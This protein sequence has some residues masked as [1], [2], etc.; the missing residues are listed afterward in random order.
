M[1]FADCTSNFTSNCGF[2]ETTI[3][4]SFFKIS[5]NRFSS[6]PIYHPHWQF[7]FR[8]HKVRRNGGLWGSKCLMKRWPFVLQN[9][10]FR[11]NGGLYCSKS[12]LKWRSLVLFLM[13]I[14]D[15]VQICQFIQTKEPFFPEKYVKLIWVFQTKL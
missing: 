13:W 10:H 5:W 3:V 15:W 6:L 8:S 4:A 12:R 2:F 7:P 14:C 9:S 1:A 11:Q